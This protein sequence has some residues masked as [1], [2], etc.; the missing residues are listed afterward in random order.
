MK[1][2]EHPKHAASA[3]TPYVC[4]PSSVFDSVQEKQSQNSVPIAKVTPADIFA[5]DTL[6]AKVPTNSNR[7]LLTRSEA[8]PFSLSLLLRSPGE[9]E[10]VKTRP[11]EVCGADM[12]HEHLQTLHFHQQIDSLW[13]R[14]VL[15]ME[16][17]NLPH[18]PHQVFHRLL[19][20]LALLVLLSNLAGQRPNVLMP[21]GADI[22]N[23]SL[24]SVVEGLL[25]GQRRNQGPCYSE[26]STL[27]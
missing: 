17:N 3:L 14:I 23:V 16:R 24:E 19:L 25:H 5:R 1:R 21:P 27:W 8:P 15:D 12:L 6:R 2:T 4:S 10:Q 13:L 26:G 18:Q 7:A 20:S 9:A 22:L 11:P